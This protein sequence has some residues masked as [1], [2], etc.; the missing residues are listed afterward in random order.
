MSKISIIIPI[1][2]S[3]E[4]IT[5]CLDSIVNQ[6][7]KNL[8]IICVND[9]STDESLK[10]LKKY[11]NKDNRII[12][13]DKKNEGVS[14]ARNDGIKK[15]TG[16][17]ITFID[18]DDWIEL[19]AIET[20]YNTL[21]EKNVDVVRGN[22]Y[23]NFTE[24]KNDYTSNLYNLGNKLFL[25]SNKDFGNLVIDKLLN[26]FLPCYIWLLLIK[27]EA[28]SNI[29]FKKDIKIMEDT[30]FY[31]ELMNN[32]NSIYFLD[33]PLYHYYCNQSSCTK[34]SEYYIRNMYNLIK[35]NKYLVSIIKNGKFYSKER[36]EKMNAIHVDYIMSYFYVMYKESYKNKKELISEIDKIL[37]NKEI[38]K[39][40]NNVKLTYLSFH[41]RV[42]TNLIINRKYKRLFLFYEFRY[43][44]SKIKDIV[45]NRKHG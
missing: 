16:Q 4:Y 35:V 9:G 25:T 42:G 37:E 43:Y 3:A 31:N 41:L 18:A 28:I 29:S 40:L 27:K 15:S 5:R 12:I 32:I 17:Y 30:I 23:R 7:Y 11:K 24:D 20:L 22:Y 2:N 26:G 1:Y 38:I 13:I 10:I 44:M 21:K 14:A 8:E 34:S 36:L 19:D 45:L 6:T 39:L 33:K